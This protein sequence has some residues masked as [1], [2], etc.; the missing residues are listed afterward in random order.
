MHL[1]QGVYNHF[2]FHA[3]LGVMHLVHT[4]DGGGGHAKAYAMRTRRKA[5]DAFEYVRRKPVLHAFPYILI[6]NVLLPY[7][8]VFGNDFYYC[9]IEYLQ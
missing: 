9:F 8:D 6:C 4:H 1:V 7:F 3:Y 5:V 2:Y